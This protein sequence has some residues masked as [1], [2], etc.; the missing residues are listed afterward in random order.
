[1]TQILDQIAKSRQGEFQPASPDGYFALR[2]AARL[3]EPEAAAHYAVLAS[4]YSQENLVHA[5]RLAI[6]SPNPNVNL[7]R[8]FHDSLARKNGSEILS[9]PRLL[10]F[11]VERRAIAIASFL[12]TH[13]EGRRVL[14]LSSNP[15]RAES[16]VIY[17]VRSVLRE[18]DCKF[19]AV[20]HA[21]ARE[22]VLRAGLHRAVVA[23]IRVANLSLWETPTKMLFS[24]LSHPPCKTRQQL[25]DVTFSIWRLS[26]LKDSQLCALDAMAL[27][28]FVQTERLFNNF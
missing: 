23:Q 8:R 28:L 18:A 13:L 27:G 5:F 15:Q 25:R 22:D 16:S 12:G 10:A 17:F 20:E 11:R 4:Q 26:A 3:G 2:L 21:P 1:M 14:Q 19:T 7:S 9:R 24:S 6:S